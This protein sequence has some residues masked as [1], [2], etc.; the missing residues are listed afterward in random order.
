MRLINNTTVDLPQ[1]FQNDSLVEIITIQAGQVSPPLT[2]KQYN[3]F[4]RIFPF[5][6]PA[7]EY[8]TEEVIV[9]EVKVVEEDNEVIDTVSSLLGD[10]DD[11]D[12]ET[13]SDA[14]DSGEEFISVKRGTNAGVKKVVKK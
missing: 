2:P 11:I 12:D 7:P 9:E 10:E 3:H 13:T 1:T 5:L 6:E 4:K 14:G 8:D